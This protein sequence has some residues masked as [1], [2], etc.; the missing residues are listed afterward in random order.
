[1][2]LFVEMHVRSEDRQNEVQ[3]FVYNRAQHFVDVRS[4][5]GCQFRSVSSGITETFR[6]NSKNGAKQNNFHLIL[7]L[8]LFRIFQINFGRNVLVLFH[9]FRFGLEKS[10]NQTQT[11]TYFNQ[12]KS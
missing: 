3:Q 11:S 1:M 5:E 9:M 12:N 7:N 6:T 2:E 4:T 8:G 10:L